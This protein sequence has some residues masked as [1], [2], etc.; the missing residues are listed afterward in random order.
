MTESQRGDCVSCVPGSSAQHLLFV[1]W[2]VTYRQRSVAHPQFGDGPGSAAKVFG[3]QRRRGKRQNRERF[4]ESGLVFKILVGE[5][6]ELS[7]R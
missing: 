3:K 4:T 7:R 5:E 2:N 6:T 1:H